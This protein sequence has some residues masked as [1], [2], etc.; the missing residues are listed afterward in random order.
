MPATW[1]TVRVFISSTFRDM[2]AERDH[3]VKVVFPEL[4]ERCA[5]RHLHL[6]DVDLRWG[7]PEEDVERGKA[8]EVCLREIEDCRPF[9]VGILG[10]RY[11]WIPPTYDAPDGQEFEWIRGFEPGYSITA[12]EIYHGVL[13]N[14]AMR[15][16]ALFYF[17]DP[18]FI[19]SLPAAQQTDFRAET[20]QH[21]EKL[22]RL[23][24]R[25]RDAGL[26]VM[27]SYQR[28]DLEPFGRRV[29]EDLWAAIDAEHPA[30]TA[31]P[32]LLEVERSYHE[33]F[34]ETRAKLF[35]GQRGLLAQ[36][37][38]FAS[39]DLLGPMIVTGSPGC[40]KSALLA[41]FVEQF[42]RLHPGQ[43]MLSHFIGASP[44]STDPR[45]M[46][47]R[48]CQEMAGQFQ[49]TDEIPDDYLGL[50]VRFSQFLER[51][52]EKNRLVL[53]IDA[54]NQLDETYGSHDLAWMPAMFPRRLRLVL[55]SLEGGTL[56]AAQRRWPA[57]PRQD[58][59]VAPLRLVDQG[60]LI[61]RQLAQ[62]G[63]RLTTARNYRRWRAERMA[64]GRPVPP[65]EDRSQLRHILTGSPCRRPQPTSRQTVPRETANPLYLRLAA[66]E[67]RLFGHFD[68][69]EEFTSGLPRD[70][71]GMFN[72]VLDRLEHEHGRELVEHSLALIATGRHGLLESELL[73]LLARH[74][75]DRFPVA[76]WSRVYRALTFYLK[77]RASAHGGD[78][79]L[80]DLFHGQLAKAVGERY[81]AS[82][83]AWRASHRE[84]ALFFLRK[85]DPYGDSSWRGDDSRGFSELTFHLAEASR[86][87][88]GGPSQDEPRTQKRCRDLLHDLMR[89][90]GFRE[91]QVRVFDSFQQSK[92]DLAR[93]LRVCLDRSHAEET[94][95]APG[96]LAQTCWLALRA[97]KLTADCANQ[98]RTWVNL[99]WEGRFQEVLGA[100]AVIMDPQ[101]R[102]KIIA[103]CLWAAAQQG[104][105]AALELAL[106]TVC[107]RL[108]KKVEHW[109]EDRFF[110]ILCSAVL[111]AHPTADV[112]SLLLLS[113]L[114][115]GGWKEHFLPALGERRGQPAF[116][117]LCRLAMKAA[118][119]WSDLDK[120]PLAI[121][122][123]EAGELRLAGE[124]AAASSNYHRGEAMVAVVR[125][126]RGVD[127]EAMRRT[128]REIVEWAR[129]PRIDDM[130][131]KA[132]TACA[133]LF[134][135]S[136]LEEGA[137]LLF[138]LAI[139]VANAVH[140][141]YFRACA[142]CDLA[143]TLAK[144]PR[145]L[146]TRVLLDRLFRCAEAT[147][148]A[149]A[150]AKIA[151]HVARRYAA[152]GQPYVA[153]QLA[154]MIDPRLEC[155]YRDLAIIARALLQ[156]GC[157]E[158][159]E[160]ALRLAVESLNAKSLEFL[161]YWDILS[162]TAALCSSMSSSPFWISRLL[163]IVRATGT[164]EAIAR[165]LI[166]LAQ[167]CGKHGQKPAASQILAEAR[168]KAAEIQ[169]AAQRVSLCGFENSEMKCVGWDDVRGLPEAVH[170]LQDGALAMRQIADRSMWWTAYTRFVQRLV[171]AKEHDLAA[172]CC[173]HFLS[174]P[175]KWITDIAWAIVDAEDFPHRPR[176]LQ[177]ALRAAQSLASSATKTSICFDL[178]AALVRV[179][180]AQGVRTALGATL[181]P[182]SAAE[183]PSARAAAAAR[184]IG[185]LCRNGDIA[186]A[187]RAAGISIAAAE[188]G[189]PS[190]Y[191]KTL[192]TGLEN[193]PDFPQRAAL[194]KLVVAL[195]SK[196]RSAD[197][198]DE[199]WRSV[200]RCLLRLAPKACT[201]AYGPPFEDRSGCGSFKGPEPRGREVAEPEA[202]QQI[203]G[204]WFTSH[205]EM[206]PFGYWFAKQ[207][208]AWLD[209]ASSLEQKTAVLQCVLAVADSLGNPAGRAVLQAACAARLAREGRRDQAEETLNTAQACLPQ[210]G[211][212]DENACA[213][214]EIAVALAAVQRADASIDAIQLAFSHAANA[215][216]SLHFE[217][218]PTTLRSLIAA[219]AA[220]S[221]AP[222][223]LIQQAVSLAYEEVDQFT[224]HYWQAYNLL[225]M[226]NI[227][228]NA[229]LAAEA[230]CALDRAVNVCMSDPSRVGKIT[231]LTYLRDW[232]EPTGLARLAD[233]L[234]K[235]ASFVAEQRKASDL[236]DKSDG[237]EILEAI[238]VALTRAGRV[239]ESL[240]LAQQEGLYLMDYDR[241]VEETFEHNDPHANLA[242][243]L[244]T[245]SARGLAS[246]LGQLAA[247][248]GRARAHAVFRNWC[249]Q[250]VMS[251]PEAAEVVGS[252]VEQL[253]TDSAEQTLPWLVQALGYHPFNLA[254]A[255]RTVRA[256][257]LA[258]LRHGRFEAY[259]AI[260]RECASI[261]PA[262]PLSE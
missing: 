150:R 76:I 178:A 68:R 105:V 175:G 208:L 80:V 250:T 243:E 160:Q 83:D 30:D 195:S 88:S 253:E 155:S 17:R 9:F 141:P 63:K 231:P 187:S 232:H 200:L 226:S 87:E 114:S 8:L 128:I 245:A 130:G 117:G 186:A 210:I 116:Q 205:Q 13:N 257:Q 31:A 81:L 214:S 209:A 149:E 29:L 118:A 192:M 40:G 170:L 239:R 121:V 126:L 180:N 164:R 123:A 41:K 127:D 111:A 73:E 148:D 44:K 70:V 108:P 166:V 61:A 97:G 37:D 227:L 168:E 152:I 171:Q 233:V 203:L 47:L 256:L 163:Q 222:A 67:L 204:N 101:E 46:L 11:G 199:R 225:L 69:L 183:A 72:A 125:A 64:Q 48:L 154:G 197:P 96:A 237:A 228:L 211:R 3:L 262:F 169:D 158:Q 91:A 165:R 241:I 251:D 39:G 129:S 109:L 107:E 20:A 77:P 57:P 234:V 119:T 115:N 223:A 15:A 138:D 53:V 112:E 102:A 215:R 259:Q 213:L 38:E 50:R 260:C 85:A 4:R 216:D 27:E 79:D 131:A 90:E 89:D 18:S 59:T 35:V 202:L 132:V 58:L 229:G 147:T 124:M 98:A 86:N 156:E 103:I 23:K 34:V 66:E 82:G 104:N 185:P 22:N 106:E 249:L 198:R 255:Y 254:T 230:A 55:S 235:A 184:L 220:E 110:T 258:L 93:A 176:L 71:L 218:E 143:D 194:T 36:L 193:C 173:E 144:R 25:I 113:R 5:Q 191:L 207:L 136:G 190:N 78:A 2:H 146:G 42:R 52:C 19:D 49:F 244:A 133:D 84:L 95:A 100:T 139:R 157:L 21:A 16:R 167:A 206:S 174:Q 1:K 92:D 177:S 56:E 188:A 62:S 54:L 140:R 32:D 74:G 181:T 182:T 26:P 246:A 33:F 122:L 153:L 142:L 14:A 221:G 261:D 60:F 151:S 179:G 224:D 94:D 159:G 137:G 6:V 12:M 219:A 75:E 51:A 238:A 162:E 135:D 120:H 65:D 252:Y 7:V 134:A 161:S 248:L 217:V 242:L 43:W 201:P 247:A 212:H 240:D 189:P 24:Q 10:E 45:R 145:F 172:A 99:A 236:Q 28:H 196:A